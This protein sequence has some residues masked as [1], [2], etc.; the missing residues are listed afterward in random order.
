MPKRRLI[1]PALL[2]LS[3]PGFS[4]PAAA[5]PAPAAVS[6][7]APPVLDTLR[8]EPYG[9]LIQAS[10]PL[11]PDF[12]TL[13]GPERFV[14]DL[15][16]A[17][18]ADAGL[19][20]P[21]PIGR[22]GFRQLRLAQK[23]SGVRLVV[24][25]DDGVTPAI[26]QSPDKTALVV[27]Y[28]GTAYTTLAS[29]LRAATAP[30]PPVAVLPPGPA[31]AA[32]PSGPAP[33]PTPALVYRPAGPAVSAPS[34]PVYR[35][36]TPPPE[37]VALGPVVQ[38]V[39]R[40]TAKSAPGSFE[41]VL[42]GAKSLSYT[43]FQHDRASLDIRLPNAHLEGALPAPSGPWLKALTAGSGPG[44]QWVL[45]PRLAPGDYAVEEHLSPNHDALTLRWEKLAPRRFADRPLVIV[46]A[47]HGGSDP[48]ALGPTG[49][50]EKR[51]TLA[52]AD[53]L[54]EALAERRINAVLTRTADAELYL[55]PRLDDIER[56]GAA[57]FVSIHANS[58]VNPT[59]AG[60]ETF[61]RQPGSKAFASAIHDRLVAVAAR[62]NRGV[63]QERLYVLRHPSIPSALVETGFISHPEEERLLSSPE[64]QRL[65]AAAIADGIA[66]YLAAPPLVQSPTGG[67]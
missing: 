39:Q 20:V 42:Q 38:A 25:L 27:A 50:T 59:V 14:I 44:R 37:P 7:A 40:V 52:I 21:L 9:L 36:A 16:Q 60:L 1:G 46:D 3:A 65:A 13:N 29:A 5:G 19:A 34:P 41:L 56:F 12:F 17:E 61:Y 8:Q 18:L 15:P 48:G 53:A 64:Y 22:H 2:L 66:A 63:K 32:S 26:A 51:V 28:P 23:E 10:A 11:S 30:L 67:G 24:D 49:A 58:H 31:P 54:A 33:S 6:T 43:L 62:P 4:L 57:A 45:S 35:P 47:G 55:Q